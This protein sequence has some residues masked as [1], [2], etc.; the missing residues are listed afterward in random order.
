MDIVDAKTRSRMMSSIRCKD[1]KPEMKLRKRLF[2]L[3]FRYRLHAKL[4]GRPDLLL[5]KYNAAIFVHGCFWH[6]HE[7]CRFASTPKTRSEFWSNKF[8]KNVVRDYQN[9]H[10]LLEL[11]WRVAVVW[12]CEIN[13]A[14]DSC[15]EAVTSW[16]RSEVRT[17][18]FP[19]QGYRQS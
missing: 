12:E 6:R 16:L 2:A 9:K 18:E 19:Q 14:P 11:G 1:T 8:A 5:R 15:T 4:P 13:R 7:R 10:D 17:L 3:G